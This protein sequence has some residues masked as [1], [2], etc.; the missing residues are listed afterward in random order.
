MSAPTRPGTDAAKSWVAAHKW[1]I[2]RRTSQA[3]V[4]TLFL[5]GPL[6][7]LWIVEGNL[8]SSL[9]LGILPLS[10]PF[11]LS[12]T[13][14]SGHWPSTDAFVG[15]S[16]VLAAYGL[17][18][19]R[20]FCSFVCPMNV[21]TDAASWLSKRLDLSKGWQPH[22]EV[23]LWILGTILVV[24]AVTGTVAWELINPVS[25]LHRG[26]IYGMGLG[27]MVVAAVFLFDLVVSRRGWCGHL[28]PMGAFYGLV[29]SFSAVRVAAKQREACNNCMD[30]FVVCPEPHVIAPVLCCTK[31]EIGPMI[32]SRDC[33]NCGRCIDVCAKDVFEFDLHYRTLGRQGLSSHRNRFNHRPR[34]VNS[35]PAGS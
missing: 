30:C 1:L 7:G 35:N 2:L 21:V 23:R 3:L 16:L 14:A 15:A 8:N 19:G 18:G 24:A 34:G 10:D 5:A 11:V 13:L 12:Q 17:I 22:R 33:T 25:I 31:H 29:G 28:C 6:L 27:W 4:L 20:V 32:L 26:L 9:I